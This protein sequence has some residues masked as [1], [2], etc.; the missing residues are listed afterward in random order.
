MSIIKNLSFLREILNYPNQ[1]WKLLN[2][3]FGITH[4]DPNVTTEDKLRYDACIL[5]PKN[6]QPKGNVGKQVLKGG[7]YA[8]FTHNGSY[9][10]IDQTYDRI[11][12]KW[13]PD[14]KE[15]LDETRR[16]AIGIVVD[17]KLILSKGY[18][19]RNLDQ[20]LPTTENTLFAIGS[21]TKAFTSFILGQ[22]VDEGKINWDDPVITYIP[23]F[24]LMDQYTTH[25][26]TIRDLVAHRS[27]IARHDMLWFNSEFTRSDVIKSLQYL[28]PACKLREKFQYNNLM[29]TVAGILIE[30]VTGQTWEESLSTRIFTP[31]AMLN[32]NDSEKESKKSEDFSMPYAEVVGAIKSIPFRNIHSVAPAGAINSS[33]SDTLKWVQLQLSDG[34]FL[35]QNF[36]RKETLQEMH[37]IQM[38]MT[39]STPDEE[40]YHFGYGLGRMS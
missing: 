38:P 34:T 1:F 33:I 29:Y 25:H 2:V 35:G 37:T 21:C 12:F 28:E 22:L 14:S 30:K 24:R 7:K 5:A 26:I 16:V 19:Y 8:T 4:D 10:G 3:G 20:G 15:N 9:D 18:G 31:L 11:F 32:S 6:T 17:G 27:G 23:E 39:A 40:V 36:I 13:L